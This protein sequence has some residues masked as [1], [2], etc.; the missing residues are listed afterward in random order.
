V[1]VVTVTDSAARLPRN[2]L[3]SLG[4]RVVPL[5]ILLDGHDLRDGVDELPADVYQREAGTAGAAPAELAAAYE[6]ALTDSVGAGVVAVHLSA[7]LSST[8]GSAKHAARAFD[9]RV[10]VVD[11]RSAAMG[12]GFVAL[13]AARAASEGAELEHVVAQASS[14]VDRV[15]AFIVVQRLDNLRRSGRIGTAASWL[16]TALAIKPLLRIDA[17][18]LVLGQRVR[19]TSRAIAAMVEQVLEVVGEQRAEFA[20]Q[21]VDNAGAAAEVAATLESAL[22]ACGP[23]IVTDLGP[24]LGV[25]LGPGAVGVVVCVAR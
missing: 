18:R 16:G 7:E 19:T 15:H 25:H 4:I 22:P 5:H 17:G 20:V 13:A 21:H 3:Q 6:A 9:G 2:L 23:A 1:P 11:S 8:M 14:A 12:S 10:A 24:V